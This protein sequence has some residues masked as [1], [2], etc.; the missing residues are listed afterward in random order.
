M[1]LAGRTVLVTGGAGFVGSHVCESLV[2]A[3]ASVRVFDDFGSGS[4]ANLAAVAADV[5]VV[6]GDILDADALASAMRGCDLVSH[7]AA[8]LEITHALDQ[9]ASDLRTNTVGTLNVLAAA[10]EAGVARVVNASSACVYGQAVDPPTGEDAPTNPNW[11]YG[12][13]KLAAEKYARLWTDSFGLETVSLRYGIVYGE[14][15]W[16]G[17]ALTIFLKRLADGKSPVVFG[18]GEQVRDFVYVGDLVELHNLALAADGSTAGESL[19]VSTGIGTTIAELAGA[20]CAVAGGRHEPVHEDVPVGER[21]REVDDRLRLPSELACMQLSPA[22][23]ERLLGW[24][25]RVGLREGLEREWAWL[26]EHCDRW[27]RM[28][29]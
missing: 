14:R 21:S 19:N 18:A 27:T 12:V 16:Y 4:R 23:A 11:A 15:E 28:S 29:Y 1:S 8:Q 3:G 17:R 2:R 25:P 24:R 5:E 7:Q 13:S 22:K 9:P 10:R 26:Q 20:A 6:E